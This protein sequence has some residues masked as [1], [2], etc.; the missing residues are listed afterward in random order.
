MECH[1]DLR[2]DMTVVRSLEAVVD[3]AAEAREGA[4]HVH[5]IQ[6]FSGRKVKKRQGSV[7]DAVEILTL[8]AACGLSANGN[9]RTAAV[10]IFYGISS[11]Y[12]LSYLELV[13]LD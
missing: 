6:S 2:G 9:Q 3:G 11:C 8:G 1:T 5:A 13:C 7:G 4:D 10:R 12:G